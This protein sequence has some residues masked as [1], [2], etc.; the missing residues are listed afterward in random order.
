MSG[1][2]EAVS[3]AERRTRAQVESESKA[4]VESQM[5]GMPLDEWRTM[6]LAGLG[7]A[8]VPGSATKWFAYKCLTDGTRELLTPLYDSKL[9]GESKP[10]A[11]GRLKL[12]L[13][14]WLGGVD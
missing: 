7:V 8:N 6:R 2:V 11:T 12:A 1:S 14:R 9:R 5:T 4:A 3:R 10:A 13:M